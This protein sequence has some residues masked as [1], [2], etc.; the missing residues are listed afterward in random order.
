MSRSAVDRLE[1][2]LLD[3]E[4]DEPVMQLDDIDILI[5]ESDLASDFF[6]GD[7]TEAGPCGDITLDVGGAYG[8]VGVLD[9]EI[10][11]D[12]LGFDR[13]E[14]GLGV[15]VAIDIRKIDAAVP[16]GGANPFV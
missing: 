12:A 2:A 9:G 15:S 13:A 14:A 6:H 16:S 10:A 8:A 5:V 11:G 7:G 4:G 1:D 3:G